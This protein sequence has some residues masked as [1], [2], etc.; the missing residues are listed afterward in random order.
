MGRAARAI[1][2]VLLVATLALAAFA[3]A[4]RDVLR[5]LA[6]PDPRAL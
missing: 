2:F 5:L 1:A 4:N 3:F 6:E